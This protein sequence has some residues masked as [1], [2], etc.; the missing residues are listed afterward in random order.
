MRGAF[1]AMVLA[2]VCTAAFALPNPASEFCLK[3]G[4]RSE[5]VKDSS[6][7]ALRLCHLPNGQ[8]IEEWT[9][10]RMYGGKVP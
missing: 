2:L 4:G 6:G 10:F 9:L 3:M 1:L 8:I 5:I 7:A